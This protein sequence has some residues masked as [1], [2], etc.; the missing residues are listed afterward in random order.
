M[1]RAASPGS[2]AALVIGAGVCAALHVGK[3]PAALPALREALGISL[4]QAGWLLSLVQLAGMTLGLA[5]GLGAERWGARRL[6]VAGLVLL[7]FSSTV[8]ATA[9]DAHLLLASRA[10]EGLGFLWA[11]LPAPA[12]LRRLL[13]SGEAQSKALGAWG[14]YMPLG[15]ALALAV[16]GPWAAAGGW[17]SLWVALAGLSLA[18][19]WALSRAVPDDAR[20]RPVAGASA[21]R[22][23]ATLGCAGPWLVAGAFLAYSS[24]WIAVIGFLP[25]VLADAAVPAAYAGPAAAL[26][27]LVNMTGNIA[28]GRGLARGRPPGQLLVLGFGA[29]ALGAAWAFAPTLDGA[30]RAA[31]FLLF[32]AAGGLVPGTLF[33]TAVRVAPR[34][35]TVAVTVGWMQQGSAFGQFVGPLAVASAASATGGWQ[36]TP[37]LT[38]AA[39]LAGVGISLALSR[40]LRTRAA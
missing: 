12:V 27:A 15:T 24:Q 35:D 1:S 40:R 30:L 26:V 17:R 22:L 19:A 23:R 37:W 14:A 32:S 28:A 34:P 31:G 3:L 25:T 13:P 20:V 9:E 7:S 6:M 10:L 29:M 18:A 21:A 39:A 38:G 36:V 11:V 16:G 2:A 33:A 4:V 5:V 8:G